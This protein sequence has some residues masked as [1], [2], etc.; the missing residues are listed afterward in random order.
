MEEIIKL[1]AQYQ[2]KTN[3]DVSSSDSDSESDNITSGVVVR[4]RTKETKDADAEGGKRKNGPVRLPTRRPDP[5][6]YNRNAL[7]ARE[8]RRKKKAHME[9]LE[10]ELDETRTKNRSLLKALKK[11][12]KLSQKLEKECEYLRNSLGSF[13]NA[14][15][16]FRCLNADVLSA[17]QNR[18]ASPDGSLISTY[19]SSSYEPPMDTDSL[20]GLLNV[21]ND[22][23]PTPE[24]ENEN[25]TRFLEQSS[26]GLQEC[27]S[28]LSPLEINDEHSYFNKFAQIG[29]S[30]NW[31]WSA[32]CTPPTQLLQDDDNLLDFQDG[33]HIAS[34]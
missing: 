17:S 19:S 16:A 23:Q 21:D 13:K 6:V 15:S 31:E 3:V 11:Q 9:A 22:Y 5:N 25:S 1:V 33:E 32:S 4:G 14:K 12:F 24:Y 26:F 18:S 20:T 8:N 2:C 27:Q 28:T 34:L 10:K 7:L 30:P 29:V